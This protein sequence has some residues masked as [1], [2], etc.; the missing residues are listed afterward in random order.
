MFRHRRRVFGRKTRRRIAS[1]SVARCPRTAWRARGPRNPG[2]AFAAPHLRAHHD[3]L[4]RRSGNA[5]LSRPRSSRRST[6]TSRCSR[7]CGVWAED[8]RSASATSRRHAESGPGAPSCLRPRRSARREALRRRARR[9]LVAA[10]RR[11][12]SRRDLHRRARQRGREPRID[13][14]R[15]RGQAV[16]RGAFACTR[17]ALQSLAYTKFTPT[18]S[19][20]PT[21]RCRSARSAPWGTFPLGREVL[22][23]I[24]DRRAPARADAVS[25]PPRGWSGNHAATAYFA[26]KV[27]ALRLAGGALGVR[28]PR[29]GVRHGVASR[30]AGSA[31]D[32][33]RRPVLA[34]ARRDRA[35]CGGVIGRGDRGRG[36]R[37]RGAAAPRPDHGR[38]ADAEELHVLQPGR[39]QAHHR[40][41]RGDARRPWLPRPAPIP[42]WW[43]ASTRF[44]SSR[45]AT[46]TS[47]TPT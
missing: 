25:R 40:G 44:R 15:V 27:A 38:S 33:Q 14:R 12:L 1:V 18:L 39:A 16:H 11:A 23:R 37:G 29:V 30:S 2:R 4:R 42:T 31:F 43:G 21:H 8:R 7:T 34:A 6:R 9:D 47:R 24:N 32:A 3:C 17:A 41:H 19:L 22:G 10:R 45:T 28:L 26:E 20:P 46:S 36:H 35:A 5:P 13:R